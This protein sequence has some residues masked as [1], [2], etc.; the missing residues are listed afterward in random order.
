[1]NMA[2]QCAKKKRCLNPEVLMV[3]DGNAKQM[4]M[5]LQ[6]AKQKKK[7]KGEERIAVYQVKK[8]G[9]TVLNS[10]PGEDK[11]ADLTEPLPT[12]VIQ[13]TTIPI[14]HTDVKKI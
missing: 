2:R 1:M 13:I 8:D 12:P 11:Y 6:Y 7:R 3:K 9:A 5:E 14:A 10:A 4:N